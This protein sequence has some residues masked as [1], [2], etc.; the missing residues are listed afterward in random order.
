MPFLGVLI[1]SECKILKQ[2][3]NLVC[4]FYFP[5]L[6]ILIECGVGVSP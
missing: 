2:N 3:L 1:Q 6:H 4:Q 5:Y